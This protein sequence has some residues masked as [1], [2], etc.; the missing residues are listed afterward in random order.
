LLSLFLQMSFHV[1]QYASYAHPGAYTS[2][3]HTAFAGAY[4]QAAFPQF[5]VADN[6]AAADAQS[7]ADEAAASQQVSVSGFAGQ[8]FVD[9]AAFYGG[10]Y[11][12]P[13]FHQGATIIGAPHQQ[14]FLAPTA[15]VP[16][17]APRV[18]QPGYNERLVAWR[19]RQKAFNRYKR[20]T[21]EAIRNASSAHHT[22]LYTAPGAPAIAPTVFAQP[23]YFGAQP[24]VIGGYAPFPAYAG[25]TYLGPSSY[26][27]PQAFPQEQAQEQ[28]QEYHQD[29]FGFQNNQQEVQ[30]EE[31]EIRGTQV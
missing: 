8:Q 20:Q 31:P 6:G 27:L 18:R 17:A 14:T 22:A 10:A 28:Q 21:K 11:A 24:T 29:S 13:A 7:Q 19:N 2:F 5:A 16:V 30:Q 12:H 26:L 25:A 4:P 15:L 1:P 23:T 3:G 9:P